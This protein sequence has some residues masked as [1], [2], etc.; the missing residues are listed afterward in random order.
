LNADAL[1]AQLQLQPHPEGGYFRETFRDRNDGRAHSTAIYF[2]LKAGEVS[3]WHRVDAAEAWH[4]YRGAP[5]E[6]R[7]G[8]SVQ[9]LGPEIEKGQQ[10]QLIVPPKEWQA[11]RSL[12]EYTLVGCTVAPGFEFSKFE[13]APDG[14]AP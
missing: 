13:M 2:L 4:F 1:I 9:I 7:I 10:P 5:L 6:L 12:G 3:R 14:F 11:A 8:N